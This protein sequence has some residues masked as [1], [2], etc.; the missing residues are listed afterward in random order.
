MSGDSSASHL[1]ALA[2]GDETDDERHPLKMTTKESSQR[3]GR[4]Q[5]SQK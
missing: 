3:Q 1:P 4:I 2:N 5:Q